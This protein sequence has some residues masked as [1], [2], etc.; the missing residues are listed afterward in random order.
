MNNE[1]TLPS[2]KKAIIKEINAGEFLDATDSGDDK[3]LPKREIARRII[4]AA[5]VSIDG[6]TESIPNAIRGLSVKDFLELS[7][8]VNKVVSG[9]F[10]EPKNP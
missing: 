8:E 1:L 2:G 7:K 5:V 10:T 4:N 9:D 6:V 3:E